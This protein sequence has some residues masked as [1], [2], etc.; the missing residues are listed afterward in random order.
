MEQYTRKDKRVN[1]GDIEDD[2][3]YHKTRVPLFWHLSRISRL[4]KFPNCRVPNKSYELKIFT[5]S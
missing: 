1:V 2:E 4:S 5:Y 3:V